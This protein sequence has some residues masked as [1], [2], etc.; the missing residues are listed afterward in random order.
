MNTDLFV[1][2]IILFLGLEFSD[3]IAKHV[4][5]LST[6]VQKKEYA[7]KTPKSSNDNIHIHIHVHIHIHIDFS[8][9]EYIVNLF[10]DLVKSLEGSEKLVTQ[11]EKQQGT[12]S[13]R[14]Y[15]KYLKGAGVGFMIFVIFLCAIETFGRTSADW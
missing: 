10:L 3:L 6:G 15:K 5:T 12:L 11:E 1:S 9:Q 8:S 4:G 2:K 14:V 7:P 13:W